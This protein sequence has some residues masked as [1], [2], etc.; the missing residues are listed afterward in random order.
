MYKNDEIKITKVGYKIL[1]SAAVAGGILGSVA[2]TNANSAL[3]K[4][5]SQVAEVA[6]SKA[7]KATTVQK[8]QLK[9]NA[10]TYNQK[11]KRVGKKALKKNKIVN[12]YGTKV[13]KGKK[14][15]LLDNGKYLKADNVK[16]AKTVTVTKTTR[17]YNSKGKKAGKTT[18]KSG[19]SVATYGTKK[20]KGKKYYSLGNGK[21]LPV[22][23]AK[24]QTSAAKPAPSESAKPDKQP[25]EN[26]QSNKP[27][28]SAT[29]TNTS[30]A[31]S[32]SGTAAPS[33]PSNSNGT[34]AI[35]TPDKP[36]DNKPATTPNKPD[37]GSDNSNS[38]PAKVS[39][40]AEQAS[41]VAT[42]MRP[43]V[44]QV[45]KGLEGLRS[46]LTPSEYQAIKKDL[47]EVM[48]EIGSLPATWD[49]IT[50][51]Q[52][53]SIGLKLTAIINGLSNKGLKAD[54]NLIFHGMQN[55]GNSLDQTQID[56]LKGIYSAFENYHGD[57][58][59][60]KGVA[61]VAT[62]LRP[63][64]A[65]IFYA[66]N[67]LQNDL[68]GNNDLKQ[69][70]PEQSEKVQADV[71]NIL[72]GL[73]TLSDSV[74]DKQVA[75]IQTA[76]NSILALKGNSDATL[77]AIG[78]IAT[79]SQFDLSSIYN[80]ILKIGQD[81][82]GLDFDAMGNSF[83]H[84]LTQLQGTNLHDPSAVQT[85]LPVIYNDIKAI[86]NPFKETQVGTDV[87]SIIDSIEKL[88]SKMGESQTKELNDIYDA[89]QNKQFTWLNNFE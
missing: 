18:V 39:K 79:T 78:D 74:Q 82:Q 32:N 47:A 70:D 46:S 44:D 16:L 22:A 48:T 36:S 81:A 41:S 42:A 25:T 61:D 76:Y 83:A 24:K 56:N 27:N 60:L 40:V 28:G 67:S 31:P 85:S 52:A 20:I 7:T 72:K 9:K 80:S 88:N 34:G 33:Q 19:K 10:Y 15:Y 58:E 5:D 73:T 29:S 23:N 37:N 64:L 3:V 69:M 63:G 68:A 49:D 11:G 43:G 26:N 51:P 14:Y 54:L 12:L 84:I 65:Q 38:T 4:A 53:V 8:G 57:D 13:I 30:A 21:Y 86:I 77:N 66:V 45:A 75:E 2:M 1:L 50:E 35:T 6:K 71:V 55:V 89:I 62:Q 87:V 59:T 17:L